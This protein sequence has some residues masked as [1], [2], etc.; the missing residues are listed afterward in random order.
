MSPSST[1]YLPQDI[2]QDLAW[3]PPAPEGKPGLSV[4]G[5]EPAP[6]HLLESNQQVFLFPGS[7]HNS[8]CPSVPCHQKGDPACPCTIS[9]GGEGQGMPKS[10]IK[11]EPATL[12]HLRGCQRPAENV[13]LRC[14]FVTE[15]RPSP[16]QCS[17]REQTF[18]LGLMLQL[19][20]MLFC[21]REVGLDGL[22]RIASLADD[23]P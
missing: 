22:S 2:V 14:S 3:G 4:K 16:F 6:S 13:T 1:F 23:C 8:S 17:C 7:R 19:S 11:D 12:T 21:G 18:L 10:F 5:G 9:S 20:W 15:L